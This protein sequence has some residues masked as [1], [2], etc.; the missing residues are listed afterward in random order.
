MVVEFS[1]SVDPVDIPKRFAARK[2][3]LELKTQ[4]VSPPSPGLEGWCPSNLDISEPI[5][6][7]QMSTNPSDIV[8][9]ASVGRATVIKT[10]PEGSVFARYL[11]TVK[12][13]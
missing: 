1:G 7:K 11:P 2:R 3:E 13:K 5:E 12:K 9:T 6:N 8:G 4:S 10:Q